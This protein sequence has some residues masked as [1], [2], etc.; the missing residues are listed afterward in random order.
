MELLPLTRT[1]ENSNSPPAPRGKTDD[2]IKPSRR[3]DGN[4]AKDYDVQGPRW[5]ESAECR[6]RR[7][8]QAVF[9]EIVAILFFDCELFFSSKEFLRAKF[10][11]TRE[12]PD[13]PSATYD[14]LDAFFR[15]NSWDFFCHLRLEAWHGQVGTFP[16]RLLPRE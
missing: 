5:S 15:T 11:K 10:L 2:M 9:L 13:A 4:Y 12:G 3:K 1:R 6:Y 14:F 8:V 16:L 7:K